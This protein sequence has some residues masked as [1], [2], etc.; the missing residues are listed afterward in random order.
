MKLLGYEIAYHRKVYTCATCTHTVC[1]CLSE[2]AFLVCNKRLGTVIVSRI[3][4]SDKVN[5]GI[6]ETGLGDASA[7]Y[8]DLTVYR[9]KERPTDTGDG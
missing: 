5:R 4:K 8:V 2:D 3:S 9:T 1:G 7:D 6:Q